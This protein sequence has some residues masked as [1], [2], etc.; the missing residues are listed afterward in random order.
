M[1]KFSVIGLIKERFGE[2]YELHEK[3]LNQRFVKVLKT[4]G[5]NK[6]YNRGEGVYLYDEDGGRY[7]DMLGG[8]GVFNVGRNHG[9][10][11]DALK[12]VL[13]MECANLVQMGCSLLSG[14]LGEELIGLSPEG[15]DRVYFTN[16]GA[17]AVEAS[18][19]FAIGSSQRKRI[20]YCDKG[21]HGLTIGSLSVNGDHH[22]R[23]GFGE[24]LG[25]QTYEVRFNEVDELESE[26]KKGDVAGFIVESIQGKGVNIAGMDYF[27]RVQE[28]CKEYGAYLI[29]DEVQS[30]FGRTGRMFGM[31]HWGV[32]PDMIVVSKA[33][34]GGY[35]PIGGVILRGEI[36]DGVFS[37]L[38][39]SVVH[40]STFKMNDLAMVAGLSFLHVL[41]GEG[42]VKK[43][44]ELGNELME[45]LRIL[46]G[47]YEMIK[48]VRGKGLMIG[49]EF[50]VP[51]SMG[52]RIGWEILSRIKEGLIAQMVVVLL[53][54]RY[55]ILTQVA[56]HKVDIIKLIPSLTINRA[57]IE[58]FIES[59]EEVLIQVHKFP[60]NILR[61]GGQLMKNVMKK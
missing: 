29:I 42:Y 7:L 1:E 61:F 41:K 6:V 23:E 55:R 48:E 37:S 2:N 46:A 47:K 39:R 40:S 22:F 19:K 15:L 16:S 60:N 38:E 24:L 45:R 25:D 57:D 35:I 17:E 5:F 53:F 44:E 10:I 34:S 54:E 28:L 3:H 4:I 8:Y 52:L 49:I 9:V 31:D 51:K 14:L 26:L 59:L 36:L 33:L 32:V 56:G 21:F 20:I 12:E 13:D 18:I 50:G 27:D 11:R 30:G 58:Y 43:A